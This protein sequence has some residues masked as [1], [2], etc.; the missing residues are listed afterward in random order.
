LYTAL[1]QYLQGRTLMAPATWVIWIGNAINV[2]LNWA[3]IFGHLGLPALGL[4]GAGIASSFTTSFLAMGLALWIWAFRLH[5]GAW[6]AWDRR[7]FELS[8]VL[9]VARLGLP[10]GAQLS[11]EASAFTIAT[12]MAGWISTEAVASH[13]VVL[14]LAALSF[15][16]PLGVS[17]GA[18]TRVGNLIG[19]GDVEGMQRAAGAAICLGAGVMVFS[20][21]SFTLLRHQLSFLFTDDVAVVALAAQIFPI[22][23][24]FQLFDGTQV[25]AGGVLRGMGRPDAAAWINLVG[26]YGVAL[27]V[28][29]F[30][31]FECGLG[32][33]G[34]WSHSH[35]CFGYAKRRGDRWLSSKLQ[36]SSEYTFP[37]RYAWGQPL[38][39][40]PAA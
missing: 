26:Y 32:L 5:Q 37:G 36:L 12:L 34:V 40:L 6:R 27:P 17:Q 20:A 19:A 22:A 21:L 33:R 13:H 35:S 39:M 4:V 23:G 8:G 2:V 11:L 24:A 7:S 28:A 29:Y 3:L 9:Q 31:A 30:F 15:M 1:R 14:T 10:V 18:A 38:A 25:V 16:V